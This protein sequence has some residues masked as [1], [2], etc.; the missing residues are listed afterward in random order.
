MLIPRDSLRS[1]VGCN[2]VSEV[3][4]GKDLHD[5]HPFGRRCKCSVGRRRGNRS[6]RDHAEGTGQVVAYWSIEIGMIENVEEVGAKR[7]SVPLI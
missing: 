5:A 2:E 7:E 1:G 6:G 4:L 3:D